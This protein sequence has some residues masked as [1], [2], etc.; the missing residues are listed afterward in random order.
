K[1]TVLES[2][3]A[4]KQSEL[5]QDLSDLGLS[6][7]ELC[8]KASSLKAERDRLIG[9]VSLL[10]G[11]CSKLNDEVSGYKLFKEQIEAVQDEQVKVLSDKVAGLD[12][13]LMRMAL[14]LEHLAALGGA[15]RRAIDKGMQDGLA[16]GI[17]QGKAGRGLV[18]VAAYDLSAEANYVSAV[19]ALRA[20]DFPLLAQLAS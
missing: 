8:V 5:T 20:M 13:E 2:A 1:V 3:D 6:C 17:D 14:H 10:E 15:I 12:A 11:T 7:D 4:A 9:Q 19:N 18:D 16:A